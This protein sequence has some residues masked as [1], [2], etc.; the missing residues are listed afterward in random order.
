MYVHTCI[1]IYPYTHIYIYIYSPSCLRCTLL[2]LRQTNLYSWQLYICICMYMR[3]NLRPQLCWW[4][5]SP[6]CFPQWSESSSC[7]CWCVTGIVGFRLLCTITNVKGKSEF[8]CEHNG[9]M[10][11]HFPQQRFFPY[12]QTNVVLVFKVSHLLQQR[13]RTNLFA[14][15]SLSD[16]PF[17]SWRRWRYVG[18]H[19]SC[20]CLFCQ[21]RPTC[22]SCG[23]RCPSHLIAFYFRL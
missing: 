19:R 16:R 10:Q 15:N 23:G 5:Y 22:T 7:Q 8:M 2:R 6:C 20:M 3:T 13:Q 12:V 1:H 9:L 4:C 21:R 18:A 17:G 14:R 11:G